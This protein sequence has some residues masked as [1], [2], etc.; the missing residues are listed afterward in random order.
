VTASLDSGGR[1]RII[2]ETAGGVM[3]VN[4]GFTDANGGGCSPFGLVAVPAGLT[5]MDSLGGQIN[6]TTS[7]RMVCSGGRGL[8][9]DTGLVPVITANTQWSSVYNNSGDQVSNNDT[10]TISGSK[11]DGTPVTTDNTYTVDATNTVQDFLDWMENLFDC[12]A[13]IDNNGCLALTD[14]VAD[15]VS[16]PRSL[17]ITGPPFA[18]HH[19]RNL[20]LCRSHR[21]S[22]PMGLWR[23]GLYPGRYQ[24]GGWK[25][26]GRRDKRNL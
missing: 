16:L 3:A 23:L 9:T 21:P 13:E 19:R 6:I 12:E 20:Y 5:V 4:A 15:T 8:S 14:R 2:D 26:S 25:Q 17:D 1:I 11:G 7:K 24:R 18:G 10:F 22:C